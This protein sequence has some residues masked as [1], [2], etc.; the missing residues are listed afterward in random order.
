MINSHSRIYLISPIGCV[1][2]YIYRGKISNGKEIV[3]KMFEEDQ[4]FLLEIHRWNPYKWNLLNI[5]HSL[6]SSSSKFM[7]KSSSKSS[8]VKSYSNT[9][10]K[11]SN[12]YL[13][14]LFLRHNSS[15]EAGIT[16]N[17][18]S[19]YLFQ[20]SFFD[21]QFLLSQKF[22]PIFF[23]PLSHLLQFENCLHKHFTDRSKI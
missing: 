22:L 21:N 10:L 7:R 2:I 8:H 6:T 5:K 11:I 19:I 18:F 12:V 23:I 16:V 14:Y 17:S 9:L 1:Y 15:I 4:G 13:F 3:Y 20:K